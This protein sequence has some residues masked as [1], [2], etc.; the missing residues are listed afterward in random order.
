MDGWHGARRWGAPVVGAGLGVLELAWCGWPVRRAGSSR[1]CQLGEVGADP[2][3]SLLALLALA[4]EGLAAYLL[5]VLGLRLLASV[6]GAG[7]RLAAGATV[8]A[9]PAAV[10]G[11]LDLL[12]GGA[13][14]AQ[15][16]LAPLP[17]EQPP[18]QRRRRPLGPTPPPPRSPAPAA[19][20]PPPVAAGAAWFGTGSGSSGTPAPLPLWLAE[21]PAAG[22]GPG[23]GGERRSAG[24]GGGSRAGRSG[25]GCRTAHEAATRADGR[26]GG[27]FGVVP[28]G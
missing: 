11:A 8:L 10:R 20:A 3:A 19:A 22:G 24:G 17:P 15:A 27:R 12:L 18:L 23:A 21:P 16:T 13:L 6:P 9:T 14:L 28:E 4:A 25:G 26:P 5:A 2:L 1:C 7:G